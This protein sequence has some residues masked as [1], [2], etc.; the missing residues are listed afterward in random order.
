MLIV[1][2]RH[3]AVPARRRHR[4]PTVTSAVCTCGAVF[5][6]GNVAVAAEYV[7]LCG[8]CAF[9]RA[10]RLVPKPTMEADGKTGT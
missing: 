4:L 8:R 5:D 9:S 7:G 2:D 6:N 10:R 1:G 3:D